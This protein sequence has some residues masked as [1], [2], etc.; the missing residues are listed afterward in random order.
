MEITNGQIKL[1][2]EFTGET[3]YYDYNYLMMCVDYIEEIELLDISRS[4]VSSLIYYT[5]FRVD[6]INRGDVE[7][8]K[9]GEELIAGAYNLS[10]KE[11]LVKAI[12]EF[13]EWLNTTHPNL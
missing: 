2:E 5:P 7:I 3:F 6:I 11:A 1:L 12:I 9:H 13:I 10:R 8:L 4:T